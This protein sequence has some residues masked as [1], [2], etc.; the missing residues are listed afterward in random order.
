VGRCQPSCTF[1]EWS[2]WGPCSKR[3]KWKGS[4]AGHA[5][6]KRPVVTESK[7]GACAPSDTRQLQ[8]CNQQKCP[9]S[10]DALKCKAPQDVL[11]VLDGSKDVQSDDGSAFRNAKGFVQDLI[12]HSSFSGDGSLLRY[13]LMLFGS[14]RPQLLSP[15]SGDK[16]KLLAALEAAP[17][18]GGWS[19]VAEA[20]SSAVQVSQ[21]ATTGDRP[22]R[23]ETLLLVTGSHLRSS[24]A[25][26]T[27]ARRLRAVGVRIIILQVG[28]IKNPLIQGNE[29]VCHIASAPCA[30]NWLRVDS[31][32]SL[33]KQEDLG[34]YLSTIC[35]LTGA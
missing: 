26:T 13:A 30:D 29:P 7:P 35:P 5:A 18:R 10:S 23:R 31:W 15:M 32:D 34:Y 19:N 2:P 17:F 28:D 20:L 11:V 24:A 1:G 12:D 27:A 14:S 21:L 33:S 6:R 25:T 16:T 3:C 22:L 4:P 9:A 8:K